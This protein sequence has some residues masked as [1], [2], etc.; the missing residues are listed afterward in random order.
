[1]SATDKREYTYQKLLAEFSCIGSDCPDSCCHEWQVLIEKKAF[2][3]LK[4]CTA[5]S[6]G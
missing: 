1:M 5:I 3:T 6:A 4:N 2:V